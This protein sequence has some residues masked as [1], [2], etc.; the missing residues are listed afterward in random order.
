M[1]SKQEAFKFGFITNCV[2][3][4]LSIEDMRVRVKKASDCLDALESLEKQGGGFSELVDDA[5]DLFK[6]VARTA[7]GALLFAPPALGAAAGYLHSKS[8]DVDDDDVEDIK[9]Q[10]LIDE[11]ERQAEKLRQTK[12]LREI[13]ARSSRPRGLYL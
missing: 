8:T 3:E 11:Y 10:E 5:G 1:L 13:E 4:G 6:T 2:E 9:S 7:G 12:R